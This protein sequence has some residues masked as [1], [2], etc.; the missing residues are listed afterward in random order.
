MEE[1]CFHCGVFHEDKREISLP[2]QT[3]LWSTMQDYGIQRTKVLGPFLEELTGHR[4]T[5]LKNNTTIAH[6]QRTITTFFSLI[7]TTHVTS[8]SRTTQ[9]GCQPGHFKGVTIDRAI[10]I[11]HA[12]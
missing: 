7:N 3:R 5:F 9:M 2:L 8:Q 12:R 10:A 6:Q 1:L 4:E 11:C